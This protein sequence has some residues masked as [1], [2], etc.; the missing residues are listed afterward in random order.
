MT[1]LPALRLRQSLFELILIA[2][3]AIYGLR[4]YLNF[5]ATLTISGWEAQWLTGSAQFAADNLRDR[6]TLP[7]WQPYFNHGEPTV[8]NT[9][10]FLLNP[11]QTLPSLI[12]GYPNGLKISIVLSAVIAGWGG[13]YLARVLGFGVAAR[14]LLGLLFAV[15]G[16][17]HASLAEGFFQLGIT[18]SYLPWVAAAAVALVKFRESRRP[19]VL[20]A[21][22]ITLVFFGGNVY[23]TLPA[24]I[25]AL[26]IGG[27]YLVQRDPAAGR[28][29]RLDRVIARRLGLALLLTIGL[30]AVTLLPTLLT[31]GYI[32]RH[33][34]E[35]GWGDYADPLRVL[36][37]LFT[38]EEIV[39]SAGVRS[40]NYY[41]Y[42]MPAWYGFVVF[43]LFPVLERTLPGERKLFGAHW[44][45]WVAGGFLLIFFT[46]W[47]TATNP[48]I[49]WLREH[50]AIMGRW[51]GVN[52]ML[53]LTSFWA[54]VFAA[55][56]VDRL[57]KR[58]DPEAQAAS[59]TSGAVR[60]WVRGLLGAAIGALVILLTLVAAWETVTTRVR[61][62]FVEPES[63]EMNACLDWIQAN[64]D[65][66]F[67]SVWA[68]DYSNASAFLRTGIR[69]SNISADYDPLGLAPTL[70]NADL[71]EAAPDWAILYF[72]KERE[73]FGG[74]GWTPEPG[75]PLMDGVPCAWRNPNALGYVFTIPYAD[76]VSHP[77]PDLLADR[78]FPALTPLTTRIDAYTW[79][80]GRI[81]IPIDNPTDEPL[82]LVVQD[83][84]WPGWVVRLDGQ[85]APLESVGQLIGVVVPPHSAPTVEFEFT[86][87]LLGV[88]AIISGL[89][90]LCALLYLLR[91]ERWL[92]PRV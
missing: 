36:A 47:G 86:T 18:Q 72:A 67:I 4:A 44:R 68:L 80:P 24:L 55:L 12:V 70:Y 40:E 9:V 26:S 31:S 87:P 58:I 82:V 27:I 74:R 54:A 22:W 30:A 38:S 33:L 78:R 56:A 7:L 19:V 71:S 43:I 84:A 10:A 91:A 65:A 5:D 42:T 46:T 92:K 77:L 50:T 79:V 51:R 48:L 8:D 16:P 34:A 15:K 88:G 28:S 90:G 1:S 63:A 62:G 45:V 23:Y 75:S 41:L 37:Q 66:P 59:L 89:T 35:P 61:A 14:L 29:F 57:W 53:T 2:A 25:M 20:L 49:G 39:L 6:G 64:D 21:V 81:T 32:G 11:F 52:R 85:P 3:F 17:Q 13:W 83:V 76:L 60:V 69:L 73:L